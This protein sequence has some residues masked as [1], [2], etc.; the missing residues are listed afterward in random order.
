[1]FEVIPGRNSGAGLVQRDA[2]FECAFPGGA[3]VRAEALDV[4]A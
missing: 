4:A 2:A 3:G 1:M